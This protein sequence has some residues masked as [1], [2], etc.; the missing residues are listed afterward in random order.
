MN[1]VV[2]NMNLMPPGVEKQYLSDAEI[3]AMFKAD[4]QLAWGQLYD[5]YAAVMFA[6]ILRLTDDIAMAEKILVQSFSTLN[7]NNNFT[8]ANKILSAFLLHHVH[9]TA[10]TYLASRFISLK[11]TAIFNKKFPLIDRFLY[12]LHSVK[13]ASCLHRLSEKELRLKLRAELMEYR[14][15]KAENKLSQKTNFK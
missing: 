15:F 5:K 1:C 9:T 12:Q 13:E 3:V 11:K 7:I 14:N 4:N 2:V 10:T 6:A 8:S